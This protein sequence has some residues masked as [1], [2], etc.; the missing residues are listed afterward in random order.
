MTLALDGDLTLLVS[1]GDEQRVQLTP[2][3]PESV[4]APVEAGQAV[5]SVTVALDGRAVARI[6]V[7]AVEA[8]AARGLGLGRIWSRWVLIR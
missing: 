3:L 5:G 8:V 7:V 4:P 6:P 2:D 1:K